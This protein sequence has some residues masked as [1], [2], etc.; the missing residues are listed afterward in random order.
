MNRHREAVTVWA[1]F[2]SGQIRTACTCSSNEA[3]FHGL[4]LSYHRREHVRPTFHRLYS[5]LL[6]YLQLG[7]CVKGFDRFL[8]EPVHNNCKRCCV[9][10]RRQQ[11][12][13]SRSFRNQPI[14]SCI[15]REQKHSCC[16]VA[17][18]F[19]SV[20]TPFLSGRFRNLLR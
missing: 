12:N 7:F 11:E 1:G 19:L 4:R 20:S 8:G 15:L 18:T 6:E 3:A 2:D 14:D 5:L 13:S 17:V 16:P 10:P 9:S